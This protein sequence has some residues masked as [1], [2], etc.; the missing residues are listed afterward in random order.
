MIIIH[1]VIKGEFT[2]GSLKLY[3][4]YFIDIINPFP[5]HNIP[6]TFIAHRSDV[7]T[8]DNDIDKIK[9]IFFSFKL[10]HYL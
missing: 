1:H 8:V 10:L 2:V 4:N 3:Q 5:G 6:Q 7:S 9:M